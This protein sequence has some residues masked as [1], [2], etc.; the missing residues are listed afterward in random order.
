LKRPFGGRG[1][2]WGVAGLLLA[3]MGTVQVVTSRMENQTW[4]EAVHLMA[5]YIYWKIGDFEVNWEHPPLGKL[6]AAVPLLAVEPRL[7]LE[8]E[9]WRGRDFF[10]L[11]K[12]FLYR[13]RVQPDRLLLLGRLPIMALTLLLGAV[14]AAWTRRKFG[15][16]VALFALLLYALDPNVIAH[17]RYVTTDL[18]AALLIFCTAIAWAGFL[19]TQKWRDLILAGMLLGLAL[20]AKYS[21]LFLVGLLPLT[22]LPQRPRVRRFVLV[23][24]ALL[25]IGFLLLALAYWP[26]TKSALT[27]RKAS[28]D[29]TTYPDTATGRALIWVGEQFHVPSHAYVLG[30]DAVARTEKDGRPSYVLGNVSHNGFW[31]Y[32]PVAFAVKTP[33]AVL[34]LLAISVVVAVRR[35]VLGRLKGIPRLWLA[36][37]ATPIVYFGLSMWAGINIGLRHILPV[38]PFVF[39]L[40]AASCWRRRLAP[41]LVAL[42]AVQV[43]EH[44][45]IFPHYL[46]FF[47]SLAG[48]AENGPRYL[49]D[50]NIDWGQD[51]KKMKAYLDAQGA[52]GVCLSYFGMADLGYYGIHPLDVPFTDDPYGQSNMNCIAAVSVTLLQGVYTPKER[53]KWLRDLE[54]AARIGYSIYAYDLRKGQ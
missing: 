18:I 21:T 31:Y 46:A 48:G 30:L 51:V 26:E 8:H 39:L 7:P 27:G 53:Y 6:L 37:M 17:G 20:S 3:Y 4:D 1:V 15:P 50:S 49:V 44:A 22:Y 28:F 43:Y 34:A 19:E 52:A 54:P 14:L 23:C 2:F 25:G 11:A 38:Y 45:R 10:S 9:L 29:Q 12:I 42:V 35:L 16:G 13:N 36:L 41:V 33:T 5:G 24:G 40:V 32:F 47:N